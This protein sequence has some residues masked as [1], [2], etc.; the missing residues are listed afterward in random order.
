MKSRV[1]ILYISRRVVSLWLCIVNADPPPAL[2]RAN[3]VSGS[4]GFENTRYGVRLISGV[5]SIMSTS[6]RSS[7]G[8]SNT[9]RIGHS[10]RS[11]AP[12]HGGIIRPIGEGRTRRVADLVK[13]RRVTRGESGGV[14]KGT[15]PWLDCAAGRGCG[16][17]GAGLRPDV[18]GFFT[19][20]SLVIC[21]R[22]KTISFRLG[23]V[24]A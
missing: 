24:F 21:K 7:M 17:T 9:P 1:R 4:T 20:S 14:R 22:L 2:P 18:S 12:W 15:P 10:H 5:T 16:A 3:A 6:T 19:V 8:G 11:G 23:T 13:D